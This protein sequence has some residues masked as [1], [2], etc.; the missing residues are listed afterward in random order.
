MIDFNP[1]WNILDPVIQ[2][3]NEY[4]ALDFR[5]KYGIFESEPLLVG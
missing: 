1:P 4:L 5:L 2:V 3:E